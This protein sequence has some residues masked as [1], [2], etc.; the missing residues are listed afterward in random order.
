V[1]PP[2]LDA[3]RRSTCEAAQANLN[4]E[5]QLQFPP[6]NDGRST[7]C[8]P[9]DEGAES[10]VWRVRQRI[11]ARYVLSSRPRLRKVVYLLNMQRVTVSRALPARRIKRV[12]TSLRVLVAEDEALIAL[13]LAD[14]LE[15]EGC[16]VHLAMDGAAAM[17][18]ALSLG[19]TLDLLITD[20]NMPGMTGEDL[21]RC[22]RFERPLLPVLV[23]TGSAPA[24]GA[25]ELR[26]QG[27]G[28]GPLSLLHKPVSIE[29][30]FAV[31]RRLAGQGHG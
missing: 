24:G 28:E 11:T 21:I 18:T 9:P 25:E 14:L 6:G 23:I 7:V 13:S 16:E 26:R 1:L 2:E 5:C 15:A 4:T 19:C 8:H 17:A 12:P 10:G 27:G 3:W 30:F 20:L 29:E 31:L 22:L